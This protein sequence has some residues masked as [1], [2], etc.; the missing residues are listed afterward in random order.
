MTT[1]S[2]SRPGWRS[3]LRVL[4]GIARKDFLQFSRYP[5]NAVF[6]VLHPL[7]WVTPLYFLGRAFVTDKGA[8]GFAGYVGTGDYMSFILIGSVL[9]HYVSTVFWGMGF[10]L[11]NEMDAGVLESNWMAPTSRL[12]ILLGRTIA[13][14]LITTVTDAVFIAVSAALFGF[15]VTGDVLAALLTVLPMLI[16]LYGFGFAFA[17]VVLLIRDANTMID[18][19]S[20]LVNTLSGAQFPVQVLP[21]WLLPLALALPLTY[22]FDAVRGFL[23]GARTLL[24]IQVELVILVVFMAAMVVLGYAVFSRIERRVRILGGLGMH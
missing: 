21:G 13:S 20:F 16:A 12:V 19:T 14:L 8:T 3:N 2:L 15:H 17:A 23:L 22:G 7:I 4:A 11:K 5:M 24:P 18:I 1:T 6:Q 10:S 9:S